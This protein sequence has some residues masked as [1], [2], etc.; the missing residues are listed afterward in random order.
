MQ[1]IH[2]GLLLS[3]LASGLAMAG[4]QIA[5][6]AKQ[7]QALGIE[8]VPLAASVNATGNALPAQ[9]VIPNQQIRVVSAPLAG[10]LESLS[11][12]VNQRVKKGQLLARLQSPGLAELQ[13]DYLQAASQSRLAQN[14]LSR[15]ESLFKDGI[16]AESRYLAT[17]NV[18]L[19]SAAAASEKRQSLRLAGV[20]DAA[21]ARLQ[22]GQ[23][24]GSALEIAAPIEGVVLEQMAAP[25]Q[26]VEAAAPLFK[27]AHLS[28]LWLEIQVPISQANTLTLGAAV[29]VSTA[30]ASGKVISIGRSV[31]E[32]NQTV[33]A[34]AEVSEGAANLRPGQF[35][36]AVLGI[37]GGAGLWTVPGNALVR[38]A[39]Q[40]YVFVQTSSGYRVQAVK[41]ISQTPTAITIESAVAGELHGDERV[42]SR[43]SV[44]L[45]AAW[46]GLGG[47]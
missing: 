22:A 16:I 13:R 32:A 41:V 20:G 45:K 34:R 33:M 39:N 31:A 7:S 25:G 10:M 40:A 2:I 35:V 28:P 47:E 46:Q 4:E 5:M 21:I 19:A 26:R 11:V 15:D 30:Q 42:V 9:V 14:S 18:A 12:A 38:A 29:N 23:A 17:Q 3:L 43:G 27:V 8:T 36:E 37:S 1:F 24:I 44:A 6:T